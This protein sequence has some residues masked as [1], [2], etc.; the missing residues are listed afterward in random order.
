MGP[1]TCLWLVAL[2]AFSGGR[3]DEADVH[4]WRYIFPFFPADLDILLAHL[5]TTILRLE[6]TLEKCEDMVKGEYEGEDS[7]I[8]ALRLSAPAHNDTNKPMAEKV[9]RIHELREKIRGLEDKIEECRFEFWAEEA[10]EGV[11]CPELFLSKLFRRLL[12]EGGTREHSDILR[13]CFSHSD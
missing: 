8:G 5:R 10:S 11:A 2:V 13:H 3:C 12:L 7:V 4:S 9:E 1:V 6:E